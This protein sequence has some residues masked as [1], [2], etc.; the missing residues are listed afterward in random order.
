MPTAPKE[1]RDKFPGMDT[2]ALQLL[3]A[4]GFTVSKDFIVRKP[5]PDYNPSSRE[6][7]A[8]DYLVEEWDY[9]YDL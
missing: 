2:E 8:I 6:F 1:L 5:K 4:A 9:G 7:D 3:E